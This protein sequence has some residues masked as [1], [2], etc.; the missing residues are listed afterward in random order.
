MAINIPFTSNI[1]N[2]LTETTE[3]QIEETGNENIRILSFNYYTTVFNEGKT[4]PIIIGNGVPSETSSY[5]QKIVQANSVGLYENDIEYL[6]WYIYFGII[7]LLALLYWGKTFVTLKI[8]SEYTFIKIFIAYIFI[9]MILGSHFFREIPMIAM[10]C[11]MLY[12]QNRLAT[13]KKSI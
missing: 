3:S 12:H 1:I 13:S 11:Y 5:G 6:Q 4:L 8:P 7:G 2:L 9:V 10:L